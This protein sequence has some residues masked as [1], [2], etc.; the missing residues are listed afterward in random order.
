MGVLSTMSVTKDAPHPNAAKLLIEYLMSD[1]GQTIFRDAD[2]T[3]VDPRVPARHPDIVPDGKTMK[4]I[5][6]TPER[7][8][9]AMPGW[10]EIFNRY[11][12]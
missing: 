6:F 12:R 1:E 11:F 4:V 10:V 8:A 7:I 3:P 2:Y 9:A 5:Y